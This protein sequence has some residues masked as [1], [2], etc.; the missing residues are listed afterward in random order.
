[1]N[2]SG[3]PENT[4]AAKAGGGIAKQARK[5]LEGQTGKSVVSGQ[6]YLAPARAKKLK[7]PKE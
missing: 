2:A 5:Q 3:L 6:N 4:S 1:M 7:P